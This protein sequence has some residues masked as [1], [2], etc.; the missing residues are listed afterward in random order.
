[1]KLIKNSKWPGATAV[2]GLLAGEGGTAQAQ[3]AADIAAQ[4]AKKCSET[5]LTVIWEAGL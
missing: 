3:S 2:A 5:T 1:M 4:A